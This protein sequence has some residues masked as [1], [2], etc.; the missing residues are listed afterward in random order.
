MNSPTDTDSKLSERCRA[1]PYFT[2]HGPAQ[3][4]GPW[5]YRKYWPERLKSLDKIK[6]RAQAVS[7][8]QNEFET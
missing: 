3:S 4:P 2:P 1:R 6:P 7:L 8:D 5:E